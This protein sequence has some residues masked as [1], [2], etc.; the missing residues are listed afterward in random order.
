[1]ILIISPFKMSATKESMGCRLCGYDAGASSCTGK[2]FDNM[3]PEKTSPEV[4]LKQWVKIHFG[5]QDKM[6]EVLNWATKTASR[7]IN[8]SPHNFFKHR[9]VLRNHT[10]TDVLELTRMIDQRERE[11]L[12]S[13]QFRDRD[14]HAETLDVV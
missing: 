14:S 5:S 8:H 6:D 9:A 4:S 13:T 2:C 3:T 10:K 7:Y 12:A 1:M 11:I